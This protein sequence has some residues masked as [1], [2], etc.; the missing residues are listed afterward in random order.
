MNA[1]HIRH[2][3][4]AV[5][6]IQIRTHYEPGCSSAVPVKRP[7]RT[8][9]NGTPT[10][11]AGPRLPCANGRLDSRAAVGNSPFMHA[12]RQLLTSMMTVSLSSML[13]GCATSLDKQLPDIGVLPAQSGL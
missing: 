4:E 10:H 13:V 7:Q 5:L 8:L 6:L 11:C 1:F 9:A 3:A 12:T 2:R